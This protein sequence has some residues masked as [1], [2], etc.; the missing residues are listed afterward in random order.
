M[1]G[2]EIW[3]GEL[4]DYKYALRLD[5]EEYPAVIVYEFDSNSTRHYLFIIEYSD[6]RPNWQLITR[7][8]ALAAYDLLNRGGEFTTLNFPGTTIRRSVDELSRLH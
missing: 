6:A 2:S 3:I 8:A 7:D 4:R 1:K 5:R